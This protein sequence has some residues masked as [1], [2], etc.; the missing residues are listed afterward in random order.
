[1]NNMVYLNIFLNRVT[2][3]L[4][5]LT[6]LLF[7]YMSTIEYTRCYNRIEDKYDFLSITEYRWSENLN[8]LYSLTKNYYFHNFIF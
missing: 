6:Y 5:N 4:S 1:M 2:Y 3:F 8:S 7:L